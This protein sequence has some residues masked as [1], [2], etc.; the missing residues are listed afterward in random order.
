MTFLTRT[1][2]CRTEL[3]KQANIQIIVQTVGGLNNKP[4]GTQ[5]DCFLSDLKKNSKKNR[6]RLLVMGLM[7]HTYLVIINA[8]MESIEHVQIAYGLE[9]LIG[10]K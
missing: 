9:F 4:T 6:E 7:D 1:V 8:L 10:K 5:Y 3:D 2:T